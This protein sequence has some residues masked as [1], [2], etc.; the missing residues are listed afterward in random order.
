MTAA[1]DKAISEGFPA[2]PKSAF[3]RGPDGD[4]IAYRI[5]SD[6]EA[7]MLKASFPLDL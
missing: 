2:L 7:M 1:E 6:N 3:R 5:E 4:G